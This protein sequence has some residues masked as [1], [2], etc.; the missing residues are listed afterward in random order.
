MVLIIAA[1]QYDKEGKPKKTGGQPKMKKRFNE[2]TQVLVKRFNN[3]IVLDTV[4]ANGQY[5]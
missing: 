1:R 4:H 2:R 3:F 5:P